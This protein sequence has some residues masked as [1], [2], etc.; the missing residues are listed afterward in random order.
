MPTG[1][2]VKSICRASFF[3]EHV[4]YQIWVV[5]TSETV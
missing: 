2:M 5:P 3:W 1:K 4:F